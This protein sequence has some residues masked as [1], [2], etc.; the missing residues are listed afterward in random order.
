MV[1]DNVTNNEKN[2]N[3]VP[4]VSEH[5][6]EPVSELGP[7]PVIQ[8]SEPGETY[9]QV[10]LRRSI[11]SNAGKPPAKYSPHMFDLSRYLKNPVRGEKERCGRRLSDNVF[12]LVDLFCNS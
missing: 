9:S 8:I 12:L 2:H 11:R 7:E 10:P 6:L 1:T 3:Q 4:P 5:E